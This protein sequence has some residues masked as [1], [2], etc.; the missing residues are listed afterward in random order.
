M[1]YPP[2][3]STGR[4]KFFHSYIFTD[5]IF[6]YIFVLSVFYKWLHFNIIFIFFIYWN[7]FFINNNIPVICIARLINSNNWIK[8]NLEICI[9]LLTIVFILI[10][11]VL[12]ATTKL[13]LTNGIIQYFSMLL[14]LYNIIYALRSTKIWFW[15]Y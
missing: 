14:C 12:F 2:R 1:T 4:M 11:Y 10:V 9:Y 8:Y 15:S 3:N 5:F 6:K 7:F 13:Y